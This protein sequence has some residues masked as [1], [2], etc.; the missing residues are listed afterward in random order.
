MEVG[1]RIEHSPAGYYS[2]ILGAVAVI[3]VGAGVFFYSHIQAQK[4]KNNVPTRIS[5]CRPRQKFGAR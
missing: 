5:P 4:A 2:V 3:A 1:G